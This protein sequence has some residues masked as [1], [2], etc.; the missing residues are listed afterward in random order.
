MRESFKDYPDHIARLESAL[1]ESVDKPSPIT[2]PL[3][4]AIWAIEGCLDTFI[5]ESRE[6][7]RIAEQ[8][9]DQEAIALAKATHLLM[10]HSA[11]NGTWKEQ[12]LMDYFGFPSSSHRHG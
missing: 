5:D 10:L 7:L 1:Q 6:K 11:A 2:P 12:N 4:F 8:T 9:G 3:E